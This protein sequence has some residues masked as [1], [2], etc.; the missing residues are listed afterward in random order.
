MFKKI[1]TAASSVLIVAVMNFSVLLF[2]MYFGTSDDIYGFSKYV[3]SFSLFSIAVII[4]DF[5]L[6]TA[7]V[8]D[9]SCEKKSNLK[10]VLDAK[11]VISF[12]VLFVALLIMSL[13]Y[14]IFNLDIYHI[15]V[16][17]LCAAFYSLWLTERVR[18]QIELDFKSYN[19][20]NIE[21][22]I[23]RFIFIAVFFI[24]N[25]DVSYGVLFLYGIP[26]FILAINK[27]FISILFSNSIDM[28]YS[29]LKKTNI[30]KYGLTVMLSAG[31]YTTTLNAAVLFY[32]SKH[33]SE[34]VA[35]I[36]WAIAPL[37]II[38]L[39]FTVLRPFWLSYT[40]KTT[41]GSSMLI[42]FLSL[43]LGIA[44]L[45]GVSLFFIITY[46]IKISL[47]FNVNPDW[48]IACSIA[49]ILLGLNCLFGLL[50]SLLHKL[51]M[52]LLDLK[53]NMI[54]LILVSLGLFILGSDPNVILVIS[55]SFS[56]ILF[57]EILLSWKVYIHYRKEFH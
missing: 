36:G 55:T 15:V 8:R 24:S 25:I 45:G 37:A 27:N 49:I 42:R 33:N 51:N 35:A 28:C 38:S 14:F 19:K 39:V 9:D 50:S 54:R 23:L 43:V 7:L 6:N 44:F 46:S 32:S 30:F 12:L 31:L 3:L 26:S 21:F 56:I 29:V 22:T 57:V 34:L 40:A 13:N 1:L 20:S 47:L 52:P 2:T 53:Y 5:G 16:A 11:R 41:I 17:F 18:S 4:L 48:V 10:L